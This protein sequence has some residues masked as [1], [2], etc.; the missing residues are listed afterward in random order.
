MN[1]T[2]LKNK[3]AQDNI[4]LNDVELEKIMHLFKKFSDGLRIEQEKQI[5]QLEDELYHLRVEKSKY[6]FLLT[7]RFQDKNNQTIAYQFGRLMLDF[8][9]NPIRNFITPNALL[10]IYVQFLKRKEKKN[11]LTY[12]EKKCLRYFFKEN[13]TPKADETFEKLVGH[14]NNIQQMV[15]SP[16]SRNTGIKKRA[17]LKL[18]FAHKRAKDLKV[19]IILDEFSFNS[20]KDEFA[21]LII[22]PDNWKSLF[23]QQRPDLL[24]CESAWSGTDSVNRPWKGRIY[25]SVNF[26]KENRTELL[27]ILDYCNEQGIPTVFW[28]KEDP[29]HYP[30]RVHDFVKTAQL[31]DFVFTTAEECVEKYKNDYGIE[32]VYALPFATNPKV[33]NPIDNS[34]APRTKDMVF[35]GS[36]YANHIERSKTMHK[37]FNSLINNGYELAFYNRYYG[38]NDPNHLVPE[39]YKKYEKPSV[40]NKETS[41]VYKS[42]IFGLNFNTVVD[43]NTMFARRVFELMSSNTLVLSN[44]SKGMEKIFGNNVIFLDTEPKRLE[45]LTPDTIER[46]REENLNNVLANH[47][48]AKRF[49]YILN[50]IGITYDAA[51]EKITLVT[52]ITDKVQLTQTINIFQQSFSDIQYRLLIVLSKEVSDLESADIY[53][54][55]NHQRISIVAESYINRYGTEKSKYLE[56]DY[57]VL[58]GN[59]NYLDKN[60][61]EKALL[62]SSYITDDYISLTAHATQKYIFEP[63]ITMNN[64]FAPAHKFIEALHYFKQNIKKP[65]YYINK[66]GA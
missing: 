8:F 18:D 6:Q 30:D 66:Q 38:D 52:K 22:T 23:A 40:S 42:S 36:W 1:K 54:H 56:T 15:N 59:L 19:A 28:N 57:F 51:P 31:F 2:D 64:V 3:L 41:L 63:E 61:I 11:P 44:Y 35:A 4:I 65:V 60:N 29:T 34:E 10:S 16:D 14:K 13:L 5:K 49:E 27:E 55:Y 12:F 33:F 62:H 50:A 48:Y 7:Q 24:F 21:P 46:I 26:K 32:N 25:A 20:F 39:Q 9:K 43:S 47:T 45:E 53:S 17:P 37:L 58:V